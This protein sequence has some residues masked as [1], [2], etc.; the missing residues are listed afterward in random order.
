[1]SSSSVRSYLYVPGDSGRRLDLAHTRGADAVIAD[2][3]D[4]VAPGGK[5]DA[6]DRVAAWVVAAPANEVERWVRVGAGDQG[7][8][9]LERVFGGGLRGVCMPKVA[10]PHDVRRVA[11]LLD[12]LE[13]AA[14]RK[15]DAVLIM[16]L[17]ETA[18]GLLS[19]AGTAR[20]PRVLRLQLGEAD[21][22]ADLGLEPGSDELEL[23]TPRTMVVTASVAA[24][25]LPPVGAVRT[26]I[27]DIAALESSTWRLRRLGFQGRA[28]IHPA[29]I[30]V[31]HQIFTPSQQELDTARRLVEMYE[32][33]QASGRGAVLDE[34]GRMIDEAVIRRSRWTLELIHDKEGRI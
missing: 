16:P 9:D 10:G 11:L 33:A 32:T 3:E 6:L 31:V 25:L 30:P 28:V 21:L 24:S 23:L 29:Q 26:D 5:S 8:E 15:Q 19:A 13:Q 14:G 2:L 18:E 22:A 12:R 17:I 1:M 20:A 27:R 4:A 34:D 7:L